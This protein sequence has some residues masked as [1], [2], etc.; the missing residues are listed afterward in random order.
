MATGAPVSELIAAAGAACATQFFNWLSSRDKSRAYAQG[1]VDRAMEKALKGVSDQLD[2]SDVR[3]KVME[4]QHGRCEAHLAE[5]RAR[6]DTSERE[7][8]E[9]RDEI[10]K[11]MSGRIADTGESDPSS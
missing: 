3:M 10:E 6:L 2:R 1:A 9:L 8:R 4:D 11:L 5:V 7:R